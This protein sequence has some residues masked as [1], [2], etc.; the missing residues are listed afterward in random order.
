MLVRIIKDNGE[1]HTY[2]CRHIQKTEIHEESYIVR[3][4]GQP[5][6]ELELLP[7]GDTIRIPE[8]GHTVYVMNDAGKTVDRYPNRAQHG[9]K[10][11]R[12]LDRRADN[13]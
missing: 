12:N 6:I 11:F 3:H 2:Q 5:G 8:D 10:E 4:G 7:S 9:N 1:E 13:G